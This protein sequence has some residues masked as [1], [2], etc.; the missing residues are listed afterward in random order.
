MK[1][2]QLK[3]LAYASVLLSLVLSSCSNGDDEVKDPVVDET[4]ATVYVSGY[5]TEITNV[6]EVVWKNGIS[7]E[8]YDTDMLTPGNVRTAN[9]V[10][11]I[12]VVNNDVYAVWKMSYKPFN[13]FYPTANIYLW[14]ND[15]N[16]L[17][18]EN[19]YNINP[20]AVDVHGED[21]YFAGYYID[22]YQY[23]SI[24]KNGTREQ[25]PGGIG[26][27]TDLLVNDTD[28]LAVGYVG[29]S[30]SAAAFWKNGVIT[31]LAEG[32]EYSAYGIA[33]YG[34]D[35][36]VVGT[37][38]V[39]DINSQ[40]SALLWKNGTQQILQNP[41]GNVISFA[42]KVAVVDDKV[43]I[44]GY[45]GMQQSESMRATV[46]VNDIPTVLSQSESRALSIAIK[47][48][49]VYACGYEKMG[50]MTV[51]VMW[52]ITGENIERVQLSSGSGNA[53]AHSIVV[54]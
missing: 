26:S 16:T 37:G 36:Y 32:N 54:K 5:S 7:M 52:K 45:S 19:D 12:D 44:A 24:W 48:E 9:I 27:V 38:R 18:L 10:Y 4:P 51:A 35:I 13:S 30:Q 34:N 21:I 50:E 25:L 11:D 23:P 22:Q 20:T 33:Q 43:C 17:I 8:V 47:G 53:E 39:G 28:V 15:V 3:K 46:W 1:T 14:K 49:T 29:I 31:K 6:G 41:D 2:S 42:D 40:R